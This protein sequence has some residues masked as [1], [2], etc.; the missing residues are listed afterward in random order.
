MINHRLESAKRIGTG[1]AFVVF[2]IVFIFAF[3]IHPNLFS[4]AIVIDVNTLAAL[5]HVGR[6]LP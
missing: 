2:P 1:L 6:V 4:L 5:F 3:A